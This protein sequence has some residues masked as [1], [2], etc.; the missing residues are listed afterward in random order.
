MNIRK[1]TVAGLMAGALLFASTAH[2]AVLS[3]DF[4]GFKN[5]SETGS[6]TVNGGD[7]LPNAQAGLFVFDAEVTSGTPEINIFE[8]IIAFCIEAD[9]ILERP[10]TYEL[11]GADVYF[12]DASKLAKVEQLFSQFLGE[13]G[14]ANTDAAF[15][16]ALWEIIHD[17]SV[18]FTAGDFI[19]SGFNGAVALAETWLTSLGSGDSFGLWALRAD[20]TIGIGD[21]SQDLITWVPEPGVLALL[22]AGLIGFGAMRRRRQA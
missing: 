3:L 13:T 12:S 22:G 8:Q 6:I 20:G 10:A 5:G 11:L 2:S 4:K 9:V 16:L 1:L 14:T 18:D 21:E 15:Q 7:A 17:S 19:A